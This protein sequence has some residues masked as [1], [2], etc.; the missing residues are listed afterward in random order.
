MCQSIVPNVAYVVQL[1]LQLQLSE[2]LHL[3]IL[4][5]DYSSLTIKS[6]EDKS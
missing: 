3:R 4:I 6:P 5:T 2:I 1:Q